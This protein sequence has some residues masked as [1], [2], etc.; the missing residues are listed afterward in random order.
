[1]EKV[2]IVGTGPAGLTAALYTARADL[3][4]AGDRRAA[5]GRAADHNH[6]SRELSRVSPKAIDGTELVEKMREQA[7]RFGARFVAGEV[8]GVDFSGTPAAS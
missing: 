6:G 3:A 7:E 2:V 8:V 4:P 5:A 1:M